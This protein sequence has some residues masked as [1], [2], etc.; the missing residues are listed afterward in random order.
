M[1][2]WV[3]L[4]VTTNRS[5]VC[6]PLRLVWRT[7]GIAWGKWP[8]ASIWRSDRCV[9][10]KRFLRRNTCFDIA[11]IYIIWQGRRGPA[12]T[13]HKSANE[14]LYRIRMESMLG[15]LI[16]T[17]RP[18]VVRLMWCASWRLSFNKTFSFT[19]KSIF[20][21]LSVGFLPIIK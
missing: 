16:Q 15:K 2:I 3:F 12:K 4:L 10:L 5:L 9:G 1:R 14:R 20:Y 17:Q 11:R 7:C 19:L 21:Y 18:N 13:Q 6:C 8:P